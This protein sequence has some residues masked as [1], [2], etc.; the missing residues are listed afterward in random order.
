MAP[1]A[2]KVYVERAVGRRGAAPKGFLAQTY[3]SLTSPENA[4]VIRSVA[5]FGV[6]IA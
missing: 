4:S 3:E 2:Q 6:R 5:M 1:K